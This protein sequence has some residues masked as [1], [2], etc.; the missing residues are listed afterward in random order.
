MNA[1]THQ[2]TSFYHR[3]SHYID[4]LQPIGLLGARL[5][6]AWVFFLAGLTKIRD[7]DTTLWLFEEEYQVPLLNHEV[8]AF[9]GTAGE[10][11][12]PILLALGIATRFG[13]L[14]LSVVNIVAVISL[15]E[16]APAAYTLHVLWGV[17]LAQVII[18]GAGSLSADNFL[19]K[20][21]S[22]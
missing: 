11:V 21:F 5:Y 16:I 4:L 9:L 1:I 17:L 12:L 10:I 6:V 22:Q 15:E 8:A 3:T 2:V 19:K 13:A 7:W 18:F 20:R 14:G